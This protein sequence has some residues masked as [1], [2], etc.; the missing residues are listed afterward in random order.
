MADDGSSWT[1]P[2]VKQRNV[3]LDRAHDLEAGAV[4]RASQ[5]FAQEDVVGREH[6]TVDCGHT[7]H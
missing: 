2:P 4:E 6:H 7:D 5:T 1:T 3:S